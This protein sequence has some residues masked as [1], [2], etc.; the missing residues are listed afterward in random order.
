MNGEG[1]FYLVR[2][3]CGLTLMVAFGVDLMENNTIGVWW[4][5]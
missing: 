3:S 2:I 5:Y 4:L 1:I